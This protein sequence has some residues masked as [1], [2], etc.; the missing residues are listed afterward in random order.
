MKT[1]VHITLPCFRR[2]NL[3]SRGFNYWEKKIAL[4]KILMVLMAVLVAIPCFAQ[5]IEL[6][7]LFSL[8]GTEWSKFGIF[9]FIAPYDKVYFTSL[10]EY[11][12]LTPTED[13]NPLFE[14]I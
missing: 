1:S 2:R 10:W 13:F 4:K 9:P 3:S 12:C 5:E 8:A 7:G 6:G 11:S 14:F